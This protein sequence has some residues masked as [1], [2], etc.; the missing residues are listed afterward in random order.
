MTVRLK[1]SKNTLSAHFCSYDVTVAIRQ[2]FLL[3]PVLYDQNPR[4]GFLS[5]RLLC[6]TGVFLLAKQNKGKRAG[7]HTSF[8][9]Y[10]C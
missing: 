6:P 9:I 1:M 8:R 5:S 3:P 7:L 4:R 2:R 10:S